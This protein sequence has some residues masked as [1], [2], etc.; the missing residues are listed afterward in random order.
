MATLFGGYFS[1]LS[2]RSSQTPPEPDRSGPAR[3]QAALADTVQAGKPMPC[4]PGDGFAAKAVVVTPDNA[5][6]RV[7]S[8][9]QS[10]PTRPG[11]V[12]FSL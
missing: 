7:T 5:T 2:W 4:G 3:R 10:R 9:C 1:I 8:D 11:G 12:Q 6:T